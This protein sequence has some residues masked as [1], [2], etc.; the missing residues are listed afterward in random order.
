MESATNILLYLTLLYQTTYVTPQIPHAS[1]HDRALY[2]MWNHFIDACVEGDLL[3]NSSCNL[4]VG[5]VDLLD[6]VKSKS[7]GS[8]PLKQNMI[9]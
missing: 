9:H 4:K 8:T 6:S 7:I 3:Q 2:S 1:H 5:C